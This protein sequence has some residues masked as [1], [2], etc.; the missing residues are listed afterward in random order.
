MSNYNHYKLN[1]G[2]I[3]DGLECDPCP[4]FNDLTDEYT[5]I[6]FYTGWDTG[7]LKPAVNWCYLAE[8]TMPNN[9]P[10]R[11]SV[12][13]K[14]FN[15]TEHSIV[16]YLDND[17][18]D[19]N[20]PIFSLFKVGHTIALLYPESKTFMDG[21]SGISR[22]DADFK[23]FKCS[24]TNLIAESK[25]LATKTCFGCG[26]SPEMLL[27]C[28]KCVIATY[29]GS[30]CQ[31]AHWEIHKNLC[32]DMSSLKKLVALVHSPFDGRFAQFKDLV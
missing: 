23:V 32:P 9:H 25:K 31:K 11:P 22:E 28:G 18:P 30:E 12:I 15:G 19:N 14:D 13:V 10:L 26:G 20:N 2:T 17:S 5:P 16:W 6:G 4:C 1:L 29:C 24:H 3:E 7:F 21:S 8:I 27:K